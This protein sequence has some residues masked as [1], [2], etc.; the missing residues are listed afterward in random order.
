MDVINELNILGFIVGLGSFFL[1]GI[2]HPIVKY[3][4]YHYG[5]KSWPVFF[6]T[7]LILAIVSGFLQHTLL[8]VFTGVTAFALFW[9]TLEIFK[10]HKRVIKGQAK[11]NPKRKYKK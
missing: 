8:T 5:K 3:V 10:Q 7:G 9:S 1:T 4:E 11:A 2:F 6:F